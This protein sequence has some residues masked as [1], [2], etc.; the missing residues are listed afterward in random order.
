MTQVSVTGPGLMWPAIHVNASDLN[1]NQAATLD[2]VNEAVAFIGHIHIDGRPASAKT[3][4]SA[5]GKVYVCAAGVTWA[6]AGTTI[7]VG[8]Q[9]VHTTAGP[10]A[11]PD[12]TFDVYDDLV[13][14]TE[15]VTANAQIAATMSVGTKDIT[16]GDLIAVV[17]E[18][19]V[20]NG[21]DSVGIRGFSASSTNMRP[22]ISVF[23]AAWADSG[24]GPIC[25]IEFDDGTLG[26]IAGGMPV[27]TAASAETWQ[28]STN[29]D[30]RGMIFQVP[31]DCKASGIWAQM[32][33]GNNAAADYTATL[34]SDPTGTPAAVASVG[35]LAEQMGDGGLSDLR[36]YFSEVSLTKDTDYCVALR[37]TGTSVITMRS[38]T[39]GD[40]NYRKFIS[41]GTTNSKATR[42]G[43]SGVFTPTTTVFYVMGIIISSFDDGTGAGSSASAH[44]AMH[45]GGI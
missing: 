18:M 5:G 17:V 39:L 31:W 42:D 4:S 44:A 3:I 24:N 19:T 23:T 43:G 10:P 12:G 41:G 40:A 25:V 38:L 11:R 33:I 29:P 2:A 32:A 14:G 20:R 7:R 16:H 22:L 36:L 8:I 37:A 35:V 27:L 30:E 21:A 34:Y 13:Q 9:D 15:T 28:D 45:I 6:T 26:C 1:L